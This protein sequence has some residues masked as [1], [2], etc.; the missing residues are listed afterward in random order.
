[1]RTVVAVGLAAF[2]TSPAFAETQNAADRPDH[3]G[4]AA[5]PNATSA[6]SAQQSAAGQ[7][8]ADRNQTARDQKE[9][10]DRNLPPPQQVGSLTANEAYGIVGRDLLS[11]AGEKI[12]ETKNVVV[13]PDGK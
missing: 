10:P 6:A 12:G 9:T 1:M 2:L 7:E 4:V 3:T 13:G 8:K 11:N 5:A